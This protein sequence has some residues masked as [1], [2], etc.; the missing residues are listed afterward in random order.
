MTQNIDAKQIAKT[1]LDSLAD[2]HSQQDQIETVKQFVSFLAQ[3]N[4]LSHSGKL[5]EAIQ[6]EMMKRSG[7]TA[8][9]VENFGDLSEQ[10][11]NNIRET[12][13]S[14]L[15]GSVN[16]DQETNKKLLGGIKMKIAN[17]V[18]DATIKR[19]LEQLSKNIKK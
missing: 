14:L 12:A 17:K 15:G 5:V 8:V 2:K 18:I 9:Q 10:D 16:V 13:A 1:F 3:N 19:R 6:E 4:L 7:Q 11:M